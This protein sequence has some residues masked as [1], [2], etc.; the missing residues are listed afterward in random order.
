MAR[1]P[2]FGLNAQHK[3]A[4]EDALLFCTIFAYIGYTPKT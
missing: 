4:C 1:L 3:N 2:C